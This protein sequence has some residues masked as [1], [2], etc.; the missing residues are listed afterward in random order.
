MTVAHFLPHSQVIV[1]CTKGVLGKTGLAGEVFCNIHNV[2]PIV[3]SATGTIPPTAFKVETSDCCQRLEMR[4]KRPHL[5]LL[6]RGKRNQGHGNVDG[7]VKITFWFHSRASTSLGGKH[8]WRQQRLST[9]PQVPVGDAFTR[10]IALL[11]RTDRIRRS[12]VANEAVRHPI[13]RHP[14]TSPFL[15]KPQLR[16]DDGGLG[17]DAGGTAAPTEIQV[18]RSSG[19]R[20]CEHSDPPR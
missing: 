12:A 5:C 4:Y 11:G 3:T 7:L 6:H 2:I 9:R 16:S 15:V 8:R 10:E 14:S 1:Q 20:V 19:R 13:R 17:G 18:E